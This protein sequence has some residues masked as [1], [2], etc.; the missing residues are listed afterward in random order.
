MRT[1][2]TLD[3][4]DYTHDMKVFKKLSTRAVIVRDGRIAMQKG[5]AGDY[6]LLGGGV[7][8]GEQLQAALIREVQE[9]SGLLVIPESIREIGEVIE[10]RR[11]AFE[12]EMIYECHSCFFACDAAQEMVEPHLTESERERGYR[13]VWATPEEILFG[14]EAFFETQPWTYRDSEFIKRIDSLLKL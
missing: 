6:K 7:E 8:P 2:F 1:L 5:N 10:R 3:K 13:L 14:N 11:D 4:H 9:E 12:P